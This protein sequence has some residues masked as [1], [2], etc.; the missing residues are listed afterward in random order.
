MKQI[1]LILILVQFTGVNLTG[2]TIKGKFSD[3]QKKS[4]SLE[5]KK[6]L[7]LENAYF[8]AKL[9]NNVKFMEEFLSDDFTS[10]NQ[11]GHV[12]NKAQSIAFFKGFK[13]RSFTLDSLKAILQDT[14][15]A[16]VE[17]Y[18]TEN[19][20][21]FSFSHRL[22]KRGA[23]WQVISTVQRFPEFQKLQGQGSYKL[24]G[25]LR[26]AEG[27]AVSLMKIVGSQQV[28]INAS[29]V[30][31]GMFIMEGKAIE[32]PDMAFLVTPGKREQTSF[33]LENSDISLS[34]HI[35][36]L[37]K[38]K[39]TGSKTQDEYL[40]YLSKLNPLREKYE[41][42]VK[43]YQSIRNGNDT[44]GLSMFNRELAEVS[45]E[46]VNFQKDFIKNN[47]GSFIVPVIFNSLAG[48]LSTEETDVLLKILDPAVAKTWM[49]L[50][51][52][53][54]NEALKAVDIGK[55]APDFTLNDI[56]GNPVSL[57]S[58]IGT[59]LLLVDFWAGW[60][61]PCRMENPNLVKMYK[62]FKKE[63]F[64]I[65]GVSLDRTKEEWTKAIAAD[66]LTWTQVSDLLYW[67]NKA[68]RLYSVNS[69]PANFLLDSNGIIIARNLRGE[70]LLNVVMKHL[71]GSRSRKP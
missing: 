41:S 39:V 23:T 40:S 5:E 65:L 60:C 3:E 38:V 46:I 48:H 33:F 47:P 71:G 25:Y 4:N 14:T 1:W 31:N 8:N 59:K 9:M 49:V 13:P 12:R 7:Q 22:I 61:S 57:S 2:Q 54:R 64:E 44:A 55:K 35:D 24:A 17:G 56:N 69:I 16:L 15:T 70:Q 66:S 58:K 62:R 50:A 37:A 34:G 51:I 53:E 20:E 63:G 11:F 42:R 10:I 26:G 28:S 45:G 30:K 19:G 27:V 32:Y 18:Q 29:I 67:N 36:S 52:K 21:K 6:I 43:Y 68:A